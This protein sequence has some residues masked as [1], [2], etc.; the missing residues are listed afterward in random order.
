[1]KT[2]KDTDE[3][4]ACKNFLLWTVLD[5]FTIGHMQFFIRMYAI[6]DEDDVINLFGVFTDSLDTTKSPV[7]EHTNEYLRY[8]ICLYNQDHIYKGLNGKNCMGD[9]AKNSKRG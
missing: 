3:I 2:Y 5:E 6:V 1:M 4:E 8:A 7:F 9:P